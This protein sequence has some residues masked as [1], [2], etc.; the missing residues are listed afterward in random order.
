M[1]KYYEELVEKSKVVMSNIGVY[2]VLLYYFINLI[3]VVRLRFLGMVSSEY[4]IFFRAV[5][6]RFCS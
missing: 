6:G 2:D 5:L 1:R 3:I 4:Q